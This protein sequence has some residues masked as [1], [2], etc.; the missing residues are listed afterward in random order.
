[1]RRHELL[2]WANRIVDCARS[3]RPVEDSFVE[4]KTEL[5]KDIDHAARQLA[6]QANAASGENVLWLV[7][8]REDGTIYGAKREEA[9]R[10]YPRLHKRFD[11][12]YPRLLKC[13]NV[14]R[15]RRT[16]VALLFTT[17]DSP[18]AVNRP[19]GFREIPWRE[20][21][22]TRS[23]K[24]DEI[25]RMLSESSQ[26]PEADFI[27]GQLEAHQFK[28]FTTWHVRFR[29]K[30]Y[31][32]PKNPAPVTIPTHLCAGSFSV[33]RGIQRTKFAKTRIRL[34]GDAIE[35]YHVVVKRPDMLFI[36][37]EV[38]I[39]RRRL[40]HGGEAHVEILL[41]P[42]NSRRPL[43]LSS[44]VPF[45]RIGLHP[46]EVKWLRRHHASS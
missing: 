23:A 31:L 13:L 44:S 7:G 29:A 10:W 27:E 46:V 2:D 19:E 26:L 14:P 21:N 4:L 9:A 33:Q 30:F 43:I 42:V 1:M 12:V 24:R 37:A 15:G 6:A 17:C 35:P 41:R 11:A 36:E 38:E 28:D 16:L 3:G 22:L 18:Y 32:K 25:M 8:M 39:S 5:P 20:A 34:A 45:E 40:I